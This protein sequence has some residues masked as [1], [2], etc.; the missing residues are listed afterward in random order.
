MRPIHGVARLL[1]CAS[2]ARLPGNPRLPG[3]PGDA[4]EIRTPIGERIP[5]RLLLSSKPRKQAGGIPARAAHFLYLC[6]ETIY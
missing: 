4:A 2:P 3:R 1:D 6:V 5:K